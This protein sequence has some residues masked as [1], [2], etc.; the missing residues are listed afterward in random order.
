MFTG[1]RK[2]ERYSLSCPILLSPFSGSVPARP[3]LSLTENISAQG[4]YISGSPYWSGSKQMFASVF[5]EISFLARNEAE[6]RFLMRFRAR[7]IRKDEE[8]FALEFYRRDMILPLSQQC[9]MTRHE[10]KAAEI[11]K[12]MV[13]P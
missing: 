13:H 5:Y 4:A 3:L 10:I 1:V 2:I 6:F 9:A 12:C 7:A 8:G 11:I